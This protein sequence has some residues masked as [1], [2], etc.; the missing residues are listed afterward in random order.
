MSE[1][2]F[3]QLDLNGTWSFLP[4]QYKADFHIF[5]VPFY[6]FTMFKIISGTF[7][8][9]ISVLNLKS[10]GLLFEKQRKYK[11]LIWDVFEI[12]TYNFQPA[13]Y[14]WNNLQV[15]FFFLKAYCKDHHL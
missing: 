4:H 3:S 2:F 10:G 9:E 8:W 13:K 5:L 6:N 11:S 14:T 1:F 12:I 7:D 15:V